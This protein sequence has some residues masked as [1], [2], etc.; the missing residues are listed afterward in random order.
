LNFG[1]FMDSSPDRWGQV[2][3]KRREQVEA[4]QQGRKARN[5][6]A[7]DF[8]LG[9]QDITRMGALR[10]SPLQAHCNL[11]KA[12]VPVFMADAC[13]AN[14]ALAAPAI[15]RIGE[16]QQLAFELTRKKVDDLDLLGQWLRVLVAPGASLGGARPKANLQDGQGNLWIA[17][18]P[19]Q[20]DEHD[21]ALREKLLHDMATDFG[22]QV[23][24]ARAERIGGGYHTFITLRFDR[25]HGRRRFFIS[26]MALLGRNDSAGASYLDLAETIAAHGNPRTIASDLRE[27]FRRVLFN[28][29]TANRDDHLRNHGFIWT[30]EGWRP[31]PA[32]DMNPSTTKD[33]HVLTLDGDSPIPDLDTVMATAGYYQVSALQAKEDL[34]KLRAVLGTWKARARRLKLSAEDILELSGCVLV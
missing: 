23:S 1:I 7:W 22:L 33:E 18:F 19:A 13:L 20:D 14:E 4:G 5:L 30:P 6:G 34:E 12:E 11:K 25:E 9:V 8:F 32:Y 28:V 2:L 29:A 24:P 16:L 27:L 26:A 15:T 17:K 3:M 31:A 21:W 10:F